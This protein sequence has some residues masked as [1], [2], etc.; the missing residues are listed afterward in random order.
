MCQI[1]LS[2][3]VAELRLLVEAEENEAESGTVKVTV[4]G[5]GWTSAE[6]PSGVSASYSTGE[7]ITKFEAQDAFDNLVITVS[8]SGNGTLSV[9]PQG[10]TESGQVISLNSAILIY[11]SGTTWA[12]LEARE[13]TMADLAAMTWAELEGLGKPDE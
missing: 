1:A 7:S 4:V 12:A 9:T 6:I 13:L 10:I 5:P 2:C 8:G 3:R 11:S